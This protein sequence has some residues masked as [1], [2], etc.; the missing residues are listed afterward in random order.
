MK[1]CQSY[2]NKR[3]TRYGATWNNTSIGGRMIILIK[4]LLQKMHAG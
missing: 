1:Q 2:L 3:I 4:I